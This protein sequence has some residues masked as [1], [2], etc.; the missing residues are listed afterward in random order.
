V[1]V[2]DSL[3]ELDS[4][5]ISVDEEAVEAKVEGEIRA[6]ARMDAVAGADV[7]EAA[8]ARPHR[9]EQEQE[10]AILVVLG[11]DAEA[12]VP[13]LG[14]GSRREAMPRYVAWSSAARS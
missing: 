1:S 2:V 10:H 4:R 14:S 11:E 9:A 5:F 13:I 6:V 7:D 8:G 3:A 12:G